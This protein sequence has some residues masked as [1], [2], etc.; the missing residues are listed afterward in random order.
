LTDDNSLQ[1]TDDLNTSI[2]PSLSNATTLLNQT[3]TSS[4]DVSLP[5]DTT[6]LAAKISSSGTTDITLI[7]TGSTTADY[8]FNFVAD[9]DASTDQAY[10][11]LTFKP[12]VQ[13][14]S[15]P[16]NGTYKIGDA[17]DFTVTFDSVVNVTGTPR[18]PVTLNTGGT[19]YASYVSGSNSKNLVFRCTVSSGNLDA[20]GITLG[21]EIDLNGGTIK[22]SGVMTPNCICTALPQQQTYLL[23]VLRLLSIVFL[24][25]VM[26]LT[27]LEITSIIL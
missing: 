15:V 4:G 8:Y 12:Q 16:V 11:V 26:G 17:L 22:N 9:D 1:Q 6:K 5:L 10:L 27:T 21:S 3:I 19:V 2:Y 14:V 24:L 20:D 18:I 7:V 23:T 13:S 25:L